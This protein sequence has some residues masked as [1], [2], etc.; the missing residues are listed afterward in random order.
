[1][2]FDR[3]IPSMYQRRLLLVAVTMAAA[4]LLPV[5]QVARL[6][7]VKGEELREDAERRLRTEVFLA[8]ERGRILDRKGRVVALDR[9]SFDIAIDYSVITGDWVRDTAFERARRLAGS[10]WSS[11]GRERRQELAAAQEPMLKAHLEQAWTLF[12]RTSG[13]PLEEINKRKA[14]VRDQV[15]YVVALVR[16]RARLRE[17]A[18]LQEAGDE[19][20]VLTSEVR[21]TVQEEREA[22]V[23]LREVSD[24]VGFEFEKLG[25]MSTGADAGDV[26]KPLPII[27]GLRVRQSSRR[28]YPLD[29]MDVPIDRSTFPGPIKGPSNE[30]VRVAGVGTHVIGWMRQRILKEDLQRRPK[31]KPDG[32]LDLGHYRP[33]D[34]VGQGGVEFAREE[35]LRGARGLQVKHLDTGEIETT[36]PAVGR[37]VRLTLDMALQARIQALFDPKLGLAVV[38]PWHRTARPDDDLR[39]TSK[40]LPV[41]T[42]LNGAVVVIDVESGDVLAMASVPSFTHRDLA[43]APQRVLNDEYNLAYLNRATDRLY[44]PG[45]IVKPLVYCAASAAGKVGVDERIQCTGHFFPDKPLLYRCWIYKQFHT[46]HSAQLGRDPNGV[47]AIK[48]SCNIYFFELGRR[49]GAAGI[50]DLFTE[51]GVGARAQP[52]NLFAH[53]PLPE[54]PEARK[55]EVARRVFSSDIRGSVPAQEKATVQEAILMAIGQGPVA[56]TPLHAANAY[57]A[58]ARNGEALSPRIYLDGPHS[59]QTRQSLGFSHAAIE[60]ALS[61]L[62]GSASEEHGTTFTVTT[63]NADGERIKERIFNAPGVDIW[64]KSGT[65]DTSPFRADLDE[66]GGREEYDGDH[67]WC[68]LLAGDG[69][70]PRYAIA[71][72]IDYGGSGG[73]VAGP[74]ANQV[75]HALVGEGYLAGATLG[76]RPL[77]ERTGRQSALGAQD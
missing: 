28:D 41:G 60:R 57:A 75:V 40:D 7:V 22:H 62:K 51:L 59:V 19:R 73:R 65:A 52:F 12:A 39:D 25:A 9:P 36:A 26:H 49:L 46:T 1:M 70:T 48:V 64:A 32:T 14:D 66:T 30:I 2:R 11:M 56:W 13:L 43:N 54:Q 50:S 3:L 23:L 15:Q 44:M 20:E 35:E 6:T 29:E 58:L 33:G 5:L 18:K 76:G 63:E 68:V 27:P 61:G 17:Q 53:P 34:G 47:D 37:D 8:T 42:K 38:Q 72:V 10:S 74:L 16:E 4:G 45:S 31:T 69:G 24:S 71:V 77:P 21:V 67:S 55:A